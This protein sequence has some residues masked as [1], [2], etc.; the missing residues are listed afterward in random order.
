MHQ[1]TIFDFMDQDVNDQNICDITQ[2]DLQRILSETLGLEFKWNDYFKEYQ[3][4]DK[5]TKTEMTFKFSHYSECHKNGAMCVL[6]NYNCR[7]NGYEGGGKPCDS[8]EEVKEFF[9]GIIKRY[10]R[11]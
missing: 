7:K 3:Y 1:M 2:E 6:T 9:K 4:N 10:I 11:R 8:I 5:K